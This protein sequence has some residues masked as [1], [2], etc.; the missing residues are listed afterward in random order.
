MGAIERFGPDG[1]RRPA[2]R[3]VAAVVAALQ[4]IERS[5]ADPN[6]TLVAWNA[7]PSF[8]STPAPITCHDLDQVSATRPIIVTNASGHILY[9]NS[10]VLAMANYAGNHVPGVMRD[11][12]GQC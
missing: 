1:K 3:S 9:A 8:Y 6:Q 5:M 4:P 2:L 12:N 10:K 11:A 7:D